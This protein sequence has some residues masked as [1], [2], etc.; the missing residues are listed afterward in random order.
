MKRKRLKTK[1]WVDE[2]ILYITISVMTFAIITTLL[3]V[4]TN[5]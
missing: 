3:Y 5:Y 1:A 4:L 2:T